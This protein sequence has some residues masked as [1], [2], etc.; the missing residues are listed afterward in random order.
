MFMIIMIIM[1]I[2]NIMFYGVCSYGGS[3]HCADSKIRIR[4]IMSV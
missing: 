3:I 1:I 2:I 4:R